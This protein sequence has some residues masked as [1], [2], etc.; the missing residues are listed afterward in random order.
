MLF[1]QFLLTALVT[2]ILYASGET[3]ARGVRRFA[4][5]LAGPQGEAAVRLAAQSVRAVALGVVVT[6][7]VQS[8]A[9]GL[10]LFLAGVPFVAI[11]TAV[12]FMLSLAQLGPMLILIPAVAWLYLT[13]ATGWGTFLL[14]WTIVV[15]P[16]DNFLRPML[17]KRG[18]NLSLLLVAAGVIGGLIAFGLV[19]LFIGPVVLAV[20]S[21]LLSA[22]IDAGLAKEQAATAGGEPP[23]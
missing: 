19:G 6:A 16:L 5:R 1:L 15:G 23:I 8:A 12:M 21:A 11:L 17:I 20:S 14:V 18:A 9:A 13:G 3:A 7:I 2:A 4:L 22:W 10:G